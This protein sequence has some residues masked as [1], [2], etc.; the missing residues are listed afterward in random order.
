MFEKFAAEYYA[1]DE[2]N[3]AFLNEIQ[4]CRKRAESVLPAET[5]HILAKTHCFHDCCLTAC[6]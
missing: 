6:A 3:S 1:A 4:T 2:L 5:A